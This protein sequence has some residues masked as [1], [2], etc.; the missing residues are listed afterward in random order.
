MWIIL[1]GL[2][3]REINLDVEI[4]GKRFLGRVCKGELELSVYF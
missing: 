2:V 4:E 1:G 3:W